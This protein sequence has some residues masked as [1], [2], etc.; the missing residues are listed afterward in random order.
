MKNVAEFS[1]FL[2]AEVNINPGRLNILNSRATTVTEFLSKNLGPA[3]VKVERHGSYALGTII[4]PVNNGEYDADLLLFLKHDPAKQPADYI[5]QVYDCLRRDS[6]FSRIARLQS[7][8]VAVDYAGDFHLDLVPCIERGGQ[9]CICNKKTNRFEPTDGTGYRDW[10]N[11]KTVVTHGNLKGAVKLL[12]YMRDH[13]GNFETPSIILTTLV[14]NNIHASD[15]R[16]NFRN[17]PDTLKIVSNRINAFLQTN[18]AMPRMRNPV[19]HQ[20]SFNNHWKQSD[21]RNFREK[22]NIYTAKINAA[23]DEPDPQRSISKWR[24]LFGDNFGR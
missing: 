7:R 1:S 3:Y 4:Q 19:R 15:D 16:S 17:V 2:K 11:A 8:S 6:R 10:F 18:S 12:K 9:H 5:R 13:K 21:Y 24:E 14:G 22:F 20:E 23:W